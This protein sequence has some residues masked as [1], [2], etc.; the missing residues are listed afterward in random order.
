MTSDD[1]ESEEREATMMNMSEKP[2]KIS[3]EIKKTMEARPLNRAGRGEAEQFF[4]RLRAIES[5]RREARFQSTRTPKAAV[6]ALEMYST[7][8]ENAPRR[9]GGADAKRQR[10][11]SKSYR[12]RKE[13]ELRRATKANKGREKR[14]EKKEKTEGERQKSGDLAADKKKKL[15]INYGKSARST[16]QKTG[17][18]DHAYKLDCVLRIRPGAVHGGAR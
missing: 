2:R 7:Q 11:L 1:E 17:V 12:K 5:V 13:K 8:R 14:K 4:K 10:N 9:H 6:A 15:R 16:G 3:D 18:Q